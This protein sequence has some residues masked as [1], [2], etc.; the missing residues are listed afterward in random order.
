MGAEIL[1][2]FAHQWQNGSG[3]VMLNF[4]YNSSCFNM[5][6]LIFT[7]KFFLQPYYTNY[8]SAVEMVRQ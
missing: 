3:S 1:T 8:N 4:G 6:L 5:K 7:F 2:E